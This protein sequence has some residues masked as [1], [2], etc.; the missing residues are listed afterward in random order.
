MVRQKLAEIWKTFF[1]SQGFELIATPSATILEMIQNHAKVG[2]KTAAIA[3]IG[4]GQG[5][6]GLFTPGKGFVDQAYF[7]GDASEFVISF[8]QFIVKF[9]RM[10]PFDYEVVLCGKETKLLQK[11]LKSCHIEAAIEREGESGIEF[12]L[13]DVWG[14]GWTGPY[15]RMEGSATLCSFFSSMERFVGLLLEASNGALPFWLAPEQIRILSLGEASGVELQ[16]RLSREG[17]RVG[18]DDRKAPLKQRMRD[19]LRER[20]PY[21]IVLGDREQSAGMVSVRAYGSEEPVEMTLETLISR[22]KNIENQ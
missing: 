17:C 12:R 9:L 8:L 14:R 20:V 19:A 21:S 10:F 16:S 4:C 1:L 6:E 15:I 5:K 11:A 3:Y 7:F 18:L 13:R 22:L 2:K